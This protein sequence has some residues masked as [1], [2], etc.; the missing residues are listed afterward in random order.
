LEIP[1]PG[2]NIEW[3]AGQHTKIPVDK[4]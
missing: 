4:S 3:R 1:A 2:N